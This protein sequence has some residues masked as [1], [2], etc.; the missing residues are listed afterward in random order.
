MCPG[1]ELPPGTDEAE[2]YTETSAPFSSQHLRKSRG[3]RPTSGGS[4]SPDVCDP[5]T[6]TTPESPGPVAAPQDGERARHRTVAGAAET[7]GFVS[8]QQSRRH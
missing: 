4:T 3:I 6:L 5:Y 7:P 2:N 1:L 8:N